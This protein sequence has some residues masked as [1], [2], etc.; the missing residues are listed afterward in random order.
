M[1]LVIGWKWTTLKQQSAN[2]ILFWNISFVI[3]HPSSLTAL[4]TEHYK[5]ARTSSCVGEKEKLD[6][7]KTPPAWISFYEMW[8][9]AHFGKKAERW[10]FKYYLSTYSGNLDFQNKSAKTTWKPTGR[11]KNVSCPLSMLSGN[12]SLCCFSHHVRR[13][14]TT[15]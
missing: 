5:A 13:E 14:S 4:N 11:L 1:D 7:G 8:I 9:Q 10:A 15:F 2:Y 12:S 6:T 3:F